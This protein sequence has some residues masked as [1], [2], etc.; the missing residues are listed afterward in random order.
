M[1]DSR[2]PTKRS[3]PTPQPKPPSPA[4][5][6]RRGDPGSG[7]QGVVDPPGVQ[8]GGR[9]VRGDQTTGTQGTVDPTAKQRGGGP[10]GGAGGAS[11]AGA[12][13]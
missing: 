5:D 9:G 6:A 8:R 11:G 2:Q 13:Q 4:R 1:T 10:S 3:S 12:K 7:S